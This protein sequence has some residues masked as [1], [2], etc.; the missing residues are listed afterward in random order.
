MMVYLNNFAEEYPTYESYMKSVDI[1][2]E[3]HCGLGHEHLADY[4]WMDAYDDEVAPNEA[5]NDYFGD[6]PAWG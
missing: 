2:L 3:E 1:H 6:N 4:M 5:V